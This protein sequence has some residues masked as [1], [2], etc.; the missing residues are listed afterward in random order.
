MRKKLELNWKGV[1]HS[2]IVTM[3][4]IDRVEDKI[5]LGV[6]LS[7]QLTGDVRFSHVAKLISIVLNEA[8]AET[9]QEEVYEQMFSDGST[10]MAQATEMLNYLLSA[11]FPE[12][13]KKDTLAP[14]KRTTRKK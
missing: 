1:D 7:R 6:I 5:S 11:F 13:K 8:G 2:L 9:T 3:E 12:S 4:V 10:S 14:K